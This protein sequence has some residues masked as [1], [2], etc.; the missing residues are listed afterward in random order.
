MSC[1]KMESHFKVVSLFL[2]LQE[3]SI[4][5][6]SEGVVVLFYISFNV[7]IDRA[8]NLIIRPSIMRR[9]KPL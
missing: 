4:S 9:M 8:V 7:Y 1:L 2:K 5:I 3:D 6:G